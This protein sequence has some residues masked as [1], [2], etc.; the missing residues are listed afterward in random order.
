MASPSDRRPPPDLGRYG[1]S[2]AADLV[3]SAP[4]NLRLYEVRGL[5][6]PARS[7]GGTRRYS[8]ADLDRLLEIGHLLEGGLNL[9]GIAKVLALQDANRA[10]QARLDQLIENQ[11][12]P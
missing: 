11:H 9:A 12:R 2:V 4:Q 1:I 6:K 8:R 5:V 7:D 10:L 3:G